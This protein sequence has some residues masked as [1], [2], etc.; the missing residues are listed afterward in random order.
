MQLTSRALPNPVSHTLNY[1]RFLFESQ[2][3]VI[4]IAHC[5]NF[6]LHGYTQYEKSMCTFIIEL[7]WIN[8]IVRRD[9]RDNR[10]AVVAAPL[11]SH[12]YN[13]FPFNYASTTFHLGLFSFFKENGTHFYSLMRDCENYV[14]LYKKWERIAGTAFSGQIYVEF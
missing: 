8:A 6:F 7:G 10:Q 13:C 1:T 12:S 5:L 14:M 4:E 2:T 3:E 9:L 11:H